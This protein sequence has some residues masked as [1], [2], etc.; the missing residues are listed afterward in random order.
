MAATSSD[1]SMRGS[2]VPTQPNR[3][4]FSLEVESNK[5]RLL[6]DNLKQLMSFEVGE[7]PW[8]QQDG[9]LTVDRTSWRVT[10]W[11]WG[12]FNTSFANDLC[13][14]ASDAMLEAK[15][16]IDKFKE[17]KR[18]GR[19]EAFTV[20]KAFLISQLLLTPPKQLCGLPGNNLEQG[21]S[22]LIKTYNN[23]GKTQTVERLNALSFKWLISLREQSEWIQ[24]EKQNLEKVMKASDRLIE[25]I[26]E[27][28]SPV[29]SE[30]PK[31]SEPPPQS[32]V[33]LK[34]HQFER[35]LVEKPA[36]KSS[37]IFGA[38]VS[39]MKRDPHKKAIK[40][41]PPNY[42]KQ[43]MDRLGK[44]NEK[45]IDVEE[46]VQGFR[47]ESAQRRLGTAF[48]LKMFS[49]VIDP[50]NKEVFDDAVWI[51]EEKPRELVRTN[52]VPVLPSVVF[53]DRLIRA[54]SEVFSQDIIDSLKKRFANALVDDENQPEEWSDE[55][56]DVN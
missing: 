47:A 38:I 24:Q 17:G 16:G 37:S 51:E 15:T 13:Q 48:N 31:S 27:E 19:I 26:K 42:L 56:L 10:R 18:L 44:R 32:Q 46:K 34:I 7:K 9:R 8:I 4:Y 45:K 39:R 20:Q 53:T 49:R 54:S 25:T 41:A 55:E 23:E 14:Q 52:S 11:A 6:F 12:A 5:F 21:F 22:N 36:P 2:T 29:P 1:V 50:E 35:G 43:F 33:A 40:T 3:L 30:S 28:S